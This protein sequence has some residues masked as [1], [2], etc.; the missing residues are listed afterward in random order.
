MLCCTSVQLHRAGQR[1]QNM[2][3]HVSA[4]ERSDIGTLGDGQDVVVDCCRGPKGPGADAGQGCAWSRLGPTQKP[5]ENVSGDR[6][7][8]MMRSSSAS[9][10]ESSRTLR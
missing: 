3:V 6:M 7:R 1:R 5:A 2:L 8:L 4:L 10:A 9:R